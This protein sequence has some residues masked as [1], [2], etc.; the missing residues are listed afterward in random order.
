MNIFQNN[1]VPSVIQ[2][3]NIL[4]ST[5]YIFYHKY[6][7]HVP[8][9]VRTRPYLRFSYRATHMQITL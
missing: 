7:V 4:K 2:F 5:S 6:Y 1:I 3:L 9:S 8:L